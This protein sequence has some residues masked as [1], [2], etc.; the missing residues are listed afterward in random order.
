MG[1]FDKMFDGIEETKASNTS[2]SYVRAGHYFM[3][4]ERVKGGDSQKG[5]GAYVAIEMTVIDTMQDGEPALDADF[6][7]I[8]DG[9][10]RPGEPVTHLLQE[11]HPSFQ[12]N[13]KAFVANVGGMPEDKVKKAHC[14][15]VT[16]GLFDGLFVEIRARTVKTQRGNPFTV[17]GYIREVEISE[18]AQRVPAEQLDR[19]LGQGK[20]DELIEE[21]EA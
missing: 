4:I 3:R 14:L 21:S 19:I 5:S 17:V 18:I 20:I 10:H 11:K 16:E 9:W 15:K 7:V 12:G 2:S 13:Y 8:E 1:M 6:N